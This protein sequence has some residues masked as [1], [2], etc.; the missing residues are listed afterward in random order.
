MSELSPRFERVLRKVFIEP[1]RGAARRLRDGVPPQTAIRRL[2][3]SVQRAYARVGQEE[4]EGFVADLIDMIRKAPDEQF[5]PAVEVPAAENNAEA[6]IFPVFDRLDAALPFGTIA[7]LIMMVGVG[8]PRSFIAQYETQRLGQRVLDARGEDRALQLKEFAWHVLE[9]EH[10]PFLHALLQARWIA[11]GKP[12]RS[13][14]SIGDW[15]NEV[16]QHGLLGALLWEDAP[17]VRNAA[18]HRL[19]WIP[20]IDRG[21]VILH[22]PRKPPASPWTQEFDVDDLFGLLL[23]VS[24]MKATLD[25][26]LHRAFLRDLVAPIK[27]PLIRAIRTGLEDPALT[28][29]GGMFEQRVLAARDRMCELGWALAA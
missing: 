15:T 26:V 8:R 29:I 20:N 16:K 14:N 2:G 7:L 4:L 24:G 9:N 12:F 5:A 28:A 23:D 18:S 17:R 11:D 19:G 22:D 27:E 25:A 6:A 3:A 1:A 10:V 13:G 21:T